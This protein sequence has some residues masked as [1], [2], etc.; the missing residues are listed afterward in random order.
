MIIYLAGPIFT[1]AE[2]DW[3]GILKKELIAALRSNNIEIEIIWPFEILKDKLN[4]YE[5]ASEEERILRVCTE[6]LLKAEVLIAVLDGSQIDDG[7]AW[8]IGYF[9]NKHSGKIIGL[10]TDF[11]KSGDTENSIVNSLIHESIDLIV[12]NKRD[13]IGALRKLQE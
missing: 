12:K 3:T 9:F 4:N 5:L 10:R 2:R 11:R 1:E 13:L 6:G 7:T 8:E